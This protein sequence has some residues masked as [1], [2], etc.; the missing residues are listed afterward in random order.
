MMGSTQY[1]APNDEQAPITKIEILRQ[2]HLGHLENI[3]I[4]LAFE[5]CDCPARGGI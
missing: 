5:F 4:D 2:K 1:Q 3:G